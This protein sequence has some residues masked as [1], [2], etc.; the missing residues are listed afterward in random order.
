[1]NRSG[2]KD[3][4]NEL[5]FELLRRE[6]ENLFRENKR[7]LNNL[8]RENKTQIGNRNVL[9]FLTP[10]ALFQIAVVR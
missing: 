4:I 3:A 1:M 2:I 10:P 8:K 7:K 5:S 9:D 6:E